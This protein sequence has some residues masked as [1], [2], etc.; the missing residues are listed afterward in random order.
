MMAYR[1][2]RNLLTIVISLGTVTGTALG[3]DCVLRTTF[4]A[5]DRHKQPVVNITAD[6]VK[7]EINGAQLRVSSLSLA[8]PGIILMLDAS[9]SMKSAWNQSIDA[10]RHLL[11]QV[12]ENVTTVVFA[13]QVYGQANGLAASQDLLDQLSKQVP[14]GH[15]GTALY[16]TLALIAGHVSTRNAAIIVISDGGDDMS[17]RSSDATVSQF[18]HSAWPPVFGLILDYDEGDQ[19]RLR[20]YFKKIPAGTGGLVLYPPSASKVLSATDELAAVVL[21]SYSATLKASQPIKNLARLQL[22]AVGPNG[23]ENKQ[24]NLLHI[25]EISGCDSQESIQH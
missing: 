4:R 6:Q 16:D 1:V 14:T 11:Q 18:I 17:T 12:G 13:E 24:I 15:H 20:G 22:E 9:S 23:K 5:I 2:L 25:A 10:A 7:A 3:Q 8:K 21:S 19:Q